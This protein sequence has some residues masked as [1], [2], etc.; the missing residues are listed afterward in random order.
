MFVGDEP[1]DIRLGKEGGVVTIAKAGTYPAGALAELQP[2]YVIS[3]LV[4]LLE[5]LNHHDT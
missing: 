5:I 1:A 4:E 3:S 2:D